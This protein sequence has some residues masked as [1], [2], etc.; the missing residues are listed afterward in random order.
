MKIKKNKKLRMFFRSFIITLIMLLCVITLAVGF[1]V[2]K[3]R[4]Q[5]AI[6]GELPPYK[7]TINAE[8]NLSKNK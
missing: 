6:L 7:F 1:F 3:T 8:W 4:T 2:C 5:K